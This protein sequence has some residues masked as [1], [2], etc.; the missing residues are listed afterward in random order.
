MYN[1]VI[2]MVTDDDYSYLA[3]YRVMYKVVQSIHYTPK[4][5]I[6]LSVNYYFN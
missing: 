4:I 2:C 3:E 5:I 6:I 1:N